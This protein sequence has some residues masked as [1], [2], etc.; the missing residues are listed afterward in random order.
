MVGFGHH[1]LPLFY[2]GKRD[3]IAPEHFAGLP[4]IAAIAA[5]YN[6]IFH[7][8]KF[9][10]LPE[11]AV[12]PAPFTIQQQSGN[13]GNVVGNRTKARQNQ[14]YGKQ[15]AGIAQWFY[16]AKTYRTYGNNGHVESIEPPEPVNE[17]IPYGAY[18]Y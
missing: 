2:H 15:F 12:L 14:E 5:Y 8:R 17:Y 18:R 16:F 6:V 9:F 4:A 10:A 7:P 3:A 11:Q 1:V 13:H